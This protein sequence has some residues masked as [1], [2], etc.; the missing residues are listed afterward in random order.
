MTGNR[1]PIEQKRVQ[2]HPAWGVLAAV[3]PAAVQ[4]AGSVYQSQHSRDIAL[5]QYD[6]LGSAIGSLANSPALQGPSITV[7]GDYVPGSQH[8]GDAVGG[9]WTGRDAVGRD[10]IGRDQRTGD[11]TRTN[12]GT[13]NRFNAP[14]PFTDTG[15]GPRCEGDQCQGGDRF[16]L[17]P[18]PPVDP[19]TPPGG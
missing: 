19:E 9:N 15:N 10:N 12:W 17:P 13:G 4:V 3:L 1:A 18:A 2:H 8:I 6:W 14:G 11:D 16:P 5:A 7:G